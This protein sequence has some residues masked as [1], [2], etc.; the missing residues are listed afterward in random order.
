M[1]DDAPCS[2]TGACF[3]E[4]WPPSTPSDHRPW[5]TARAPRASPAAATSPHPPRTRP[6]PRPPGPERVDRPYHGCG[7]T[8]RRTI[9]PTFTRA[10]Q[11]TTTT[12]TVPATTAAST[13]PDHAV[14]GRCRFGASAGHSARALPAS[15]MAGANA[16]PD[17]YCH[18]DDLSNNL[19]QWRIRTGGGAT[20]PTFDEDGA[21]V[22][23]ANEHITCTQF[24]TAPPP[25]PG[26]TCSTAGR[27][28]LPT[29][30]TSSATWT[31]SLHFEACGARRRSSRA[32][33]RSTWTTTRATASRSHAPPRSSRPTARA[34]NAGRLAPHTLCITAGRLRRS[35]LVGC[36]RRRRHGF[37]SY[38][39]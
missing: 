35:P 3:C 29:E 20:A 7:S 31:A 36:Q 4:W 38:C 39:T 18:C 34:M 17:G 8:G 11:A 22:S 26:T 1:R 10:S 5:A 24:A 21:C 23:M 16:N 37:E 15:V 14:V 12:R 19:A 27:P 2:M 33:A 13:E 25:P 6:C 28:T 30:V 9:S 32:H